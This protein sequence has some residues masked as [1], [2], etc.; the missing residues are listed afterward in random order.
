MRVNGGT[1]ERA[2]E[3]SERE[4]LSWMAK[5]G[6]ATETVTELQRGMSSLPSHSA[7]NRRA[8]RCFVFH[9]D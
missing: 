5:G 2:N 8:V 6:G 7:F 9:R 3:Q 1:N 4:R